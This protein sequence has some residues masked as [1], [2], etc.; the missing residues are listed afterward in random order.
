MRSYQIHFIL[1]RQ[2]VLEIGKLGRFELPAGEYV[3]TG[4]AKRKMEARVSGIWIRSF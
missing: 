1:E 2:V 3:Y 4:S